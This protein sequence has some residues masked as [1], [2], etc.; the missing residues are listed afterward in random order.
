VRWKTPTLRALVRNPQDGM[1]ALSLATWGPAGR[2]P[3][4]MQRAA[5]RDEDPDLFTGADESGEARKVCA[6]C[7][8][9]KVCLADVE[10]FEAGQPSG[11]V[12]DVVVG[13]LTGPERAARL[14][15]AVQ[16]PTNEREGVA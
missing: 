11:Y 3:E 1:A 12:S 8:V 7:P 4:W 6:A 2:P 5:C 13:G 9:R 15:A 16:V 14:D 10:R